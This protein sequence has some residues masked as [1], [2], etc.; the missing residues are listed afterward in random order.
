V[1][2]GDMPLLSPN[3]AL[4]VQISSLKITPQGVNGYLL[5]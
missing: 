4:R 3:V 5:G 1:I 2:P